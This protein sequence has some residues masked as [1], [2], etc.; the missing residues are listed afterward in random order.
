[1][2]CSLAELAR[3]AVL[4][5]PRCKVKLIC[6]PPASGK[7]TY[8]KTNAGPRDIVIDFDLIAREFGWG[9]ERPSRAVG[10]IL[11]ERNRRLVA[12]A[13]EPPERQCW[14]IIGAASP[15]LRQWWRESLALQPSDLILLLPTR[16]ELCRRIKNDPDRAGVAAMHM[17]L[18]D[19][20]L[21]RERND[22]PGIVMGNCDENGFPTDPL[23]PWNRERYGKASTG[24]D[25]RRR[26][27]PRSHQGVAPR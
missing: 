23:H 8:V 19:Q 13:E 20:W 6:G 9:R 3:P 4:Q 5:K 21:D 7:S 1:M 25:E 16:A 12:L 26:R 17:G 24:T 14:I 11:R 22:D 2:D 18:V 15:S 27:L 10:E